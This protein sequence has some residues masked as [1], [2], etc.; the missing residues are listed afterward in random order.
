MRS[1]TRSRAQGS[2][3]KLEIIEYARGYETNEDKMLNMK[4]SF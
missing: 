1:I 4:K 3:Q 2:E